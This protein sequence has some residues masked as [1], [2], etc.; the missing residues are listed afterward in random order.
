MSA[1]QGQGHRLGGPTAATTS[2]SN[3][4][5]AVGNPT[6]PAAATA[7]PV[8]AS[9]A[10]AYA[11]TPADLRNIPMAEVVSGAPAGVGAGGGRQASVPNAQVYMNVMGCLCDVMCVRVC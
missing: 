8:P 9:G 2:S 6:T 4:A 7:V 10:T 3:R 11:T 1:F 5:G